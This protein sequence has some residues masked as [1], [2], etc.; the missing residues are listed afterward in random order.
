M[1][2]LTSR[3]ERIAA[4]AREIIAKKPVYIDTETTGLT[5]SDEI[6]EISIIDHD[7]TELYTKLVKPN[8]SIPKDATRIHGITDQMVAV[9]Q[10]WPIQWP[11]IRAILFG[12]LVAAYNVEFDSRMM[13]QSYQKYNL[14]WR[15]RLEY[16]D[17][18]KLF[19]EYRGE[20]DPA[21]SS[22]RFFKLSE[23][24]RYF[25]IALLNAHRSTAD[26]LLT[27]AVLHAIAGLA[28]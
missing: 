16:V 2:A 7:G 9:A 14:P 21:H 23:A 15:E 26:A 12:R 13:E 25:N 5:R 10:A 3:Q 11:H 19:S 27:R 1:T 17:V 18:L 24:G 4:Q 20:Y 8:Q 28:Y 22:F 6:V